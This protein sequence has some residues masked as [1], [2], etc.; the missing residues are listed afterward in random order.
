MLKKWRIGL[1]LIWLLGLFSV[2]AQ[3]FRTPFQYNLSL[4]IDKYAARDSGFLHLGQK[5]LLQSRIPLEVYDSVFSYDKKVYTDFHDK[6]Y[7]SHLIQIKD[8]N[9]F[10]YIDPLFHFDAG[11][12]FSDTSGR[13]SWGARG[14]TFYTNTRAFQVQGGFGKNFSFYTSFFENQAF[15]PDYLRLAFQDNGEYFAQT[16][17]YKQQFSVIPGQARAK[18]FKTSG[19]D[20]AW[21]IGYVSYSPKEWLNLQFG[22]GKM[23]NGF[24]YRSLLLSDNGFAM[25]HI[26]ASTNF[27]KKKWL[28]T[29][30]YT[31]MYNLYRL[32]EK[33]TPEATFV[34]KGGS[35]HQ[36][37]YMPNPQWE[38]GFFEATI[39]QQYDSLTGTTPTNLQ[40][41]SPVM[42]L[43]TLTQGLSSANN[44]LLG[45]SIRYT[46]SEN[47]MFYGQLMLDDLKNNKTGFQVGAKAFEP[48]GLDFLDLMLEYNHVS[49]YAY[50]H[51]NL[52]Q[53][54]GHY[55]LA[56]AHPYGAGFDEFV[57]INKF[58]IVR[59]AWVEAKYN[60][61][62][63]LDR[64]NNDK[65]GKDIFLPYSPSQ[66]ITDD[67]AT[68]F[69]QSYRINYKFN[70]NT[71]LNAF[72]GV[73]IRTLN[74]NDFVQPTTYVVAGIKTSLYNAYY[75]F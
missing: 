74:G 15:F 38:I 70:T 27:N 66:G 19:F 68:L 9:F 75:D 22:N 11:G 64:N 62:F 18:P 45:I 53:N 24:G 33:T 1:L 37:N 51:E 8:S 7:K 10:C 17:G 16:N 47:W 14:G 42:G 29:F 23:F 21:A 52:W 40:Q 58:D 6:L 57:L 28:Y 63:W 69:F 49:P 32:P 65:L 30:S 67:K 4:E 20:Y 43:N 12:D 71:N 46:P 35:F 2:Q 36:L 54:Y 25:P 5:P 61:A 39:W 34:P 73:D 56:L 26:T 41:Y 55:N 72:F 44:V 59:R 50:T 3:V 13:G 48:F 60:L 31:Q